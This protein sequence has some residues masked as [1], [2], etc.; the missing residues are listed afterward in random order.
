V[1]GPAPAIVCIERD[2]CDVE[3]KSS[4]IA[5]GLRIPRHPEDIATLR[6]FRP[7]SGKTHAAAGESSAISGRNGRTTGKRNE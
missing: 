4:S 3:L 7:L 2:P 6:S 5:T 1:N